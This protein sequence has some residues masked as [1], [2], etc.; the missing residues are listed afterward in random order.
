MLQIYEIKTKLVAFT[1][2]NNEKRRKIVLSHPKFQR[3]LSKL[4]TF[5]QD[6]TWINKETTTGIQN[7]G[8]SFTKYDI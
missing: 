2:K 1:D 7:S 8:R 3:K 6:P 4:F 5:W